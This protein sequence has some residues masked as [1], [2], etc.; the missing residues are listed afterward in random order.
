MNVEV[1][2]EWLAALRSGEYEQGQDAL[3]H[4]GKF[5]CLGV[6]CDLAAKHGV[7]RWELSAHFHDGDCV[8]DDVLTDKVREWA[9]LDQVNPILEILDSQ[10]RLIVEPIAELND[11]GIPFTVLADEIEKQL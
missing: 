5:C 1:K 11:R 4:N 10:E 6:L 2:A 7:G 3:R 8:A 9:G